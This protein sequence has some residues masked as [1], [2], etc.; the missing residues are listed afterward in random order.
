MTLG[1]ALAR[2]VLQEGTVYAQ[3]LVGDGVGD[4]CRIMY[5]AAQDRPEP[6]LRFT[7]CGA[8]VSEIPINLD[9]CLRM[10]YRLEKP[11]EW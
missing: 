5:H 2:V 9:W 6:T 4:V 11:D 10:T 1:E 7:I 3:A 8:S